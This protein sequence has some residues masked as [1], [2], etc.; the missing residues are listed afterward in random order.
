MLM[1]FVKKRIFL[2]IAVMFIF[3]LKKENMKKDVAVVLRFGH[4]CNVTKTSYAY[5]YAVAYSGIFQEGRGLGSFGH[6]HKNQ[7]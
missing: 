2:K 6:K 4:E 3:S 5:K 7:I 1:Y